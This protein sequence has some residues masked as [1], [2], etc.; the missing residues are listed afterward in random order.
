MTVYDKDTSV[1]VVENC[2]DNFSDDL[3]EQLR[4]KDM[5]ILDI[6]VSTCSHEGKLWRSAFIFYNFIGNLDE[7]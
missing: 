3:E 4:D 2:G 5:K 6:K 1:I 7:E